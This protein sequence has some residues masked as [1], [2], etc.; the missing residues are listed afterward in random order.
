M[1]CGILKS[2][3]LGTLDRAHGGK[4]PCREAGHGGHQ[5]RRRSQNDPAG[6][7]PGGAGALLTPTLIFSPAPGRGGR[8]TALRKMRHPQ[9][10]PEALGGPRVG[11]CVLLMILWLGLWGATCARAE[12]SDVCRDLAD[13][14]AKFPQQL[15]VGSLARLGTCVT[16]EI[17]DR[18]AAPEPPSPPASREE[19]VPPPARQRGNWPPAAPWPG[20]WPPQAPWDR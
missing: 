7:G 19:A 15:D 4:P 20:N 17:G 9:L 5:P 1:A 6:H 12:P 3:F 11:A 18:L 2:P 13:R 16:T 14:F 10:W 8:D